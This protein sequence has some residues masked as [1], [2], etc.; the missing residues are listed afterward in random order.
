MTSAEDYEGW[1]ERELVDA[2]VRRDAYI[3]R[4]EKGIAIARA[5]LEPLNRDGAPLEM[6]MAV[7]A[8]RRAQKRSK[9]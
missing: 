8:L 5:R 7:R 2:L 4:M 9:A 6:D 3:D 1:A